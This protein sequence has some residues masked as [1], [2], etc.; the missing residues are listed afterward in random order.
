M[1]RPK[2]KPIAA[3]IAAGDPRKKGVRKLQERLNKEPKASAGLPSCP[4][5]L[6]GRARSAWT[7]WAE[8]LEAMGIDRRPD[9]IM[10]EGACVAY[11]RAV[12]ADL[13]VAK[14]GLI[15]TRTVTDPLTGDQFEQLRAHPAIAI[16]RSSWS[17]AKA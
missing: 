17:Q 15:C 2:P 6:R 1:R 7:F 8:E 13:L 11:A 9:A 10:L 4:R 3:Q 12:Q 16:S 14:Q 5:D